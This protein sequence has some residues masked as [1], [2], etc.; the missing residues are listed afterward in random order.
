MA[1]S[2]RRGSSGITCASPFLKR[3]PT[4]YVDPVFRNYSASIETLLEEF[5]NGLVEGLD[6]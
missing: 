4:S 6:E 1:L 2:H 5:R 3:F